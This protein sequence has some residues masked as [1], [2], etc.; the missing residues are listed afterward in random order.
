[1]LVPNIVAESAAVH[2]TKQKLTLHLQAMES[3]LLFRGIHCSI[4][5]FKLGDIKSINEPVLLLDSVHHKLTQRIDC[6]ATCMKQVGME[7]VEL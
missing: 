1:M 2:S 7:I 6:L 3:E 5:S 4:P